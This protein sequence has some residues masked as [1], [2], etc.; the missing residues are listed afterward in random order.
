MSKL[1]EKHIDRISYS[2]PTRDVVAQMSYDFCL[3]HP[4]AKIHLIF[5]TLFKNEILYKQDVIMFFK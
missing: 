3:K 2:S 4:D 5:Q 1:I